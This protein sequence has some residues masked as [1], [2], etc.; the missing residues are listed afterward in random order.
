MNSIAN[1]GILLVDENDT[2]VGTGE[3]IT[4]HKS[5]ILHRAFSIYV[6]S[7]DCRKVLLQRRA[8]G[9][10]HSGG[11]WSNTCC[12]HPYEGEN[13]L[14]TLH[15]RLAEE[16][17][18]SVCANGISYSIEDSLNKFIFAGKYRYYHRFGEIAENELDYVF[19]FFIDKLIQPNL[20]P[21]EVL[22]CKWFDISELL[23]W[24]DDRPQDFS[25]WFI[26]TFRIAYKLVTDKAEAQSY[27]L[28]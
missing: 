19:V 4:I 10:Y 28:L 17:G 13:F 22:D 16:L 18:I 24:I 20:N 2:I 25:V 12:S 21:S 8:Y 3:K 6:F 9:K 1:E 5:G 14:D 15:N 27:T 11:L 7:A 26:P 23:H